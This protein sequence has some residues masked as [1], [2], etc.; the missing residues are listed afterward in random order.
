[1]RRT[2]LGTCALWSE[3]TGAAQP[4]VGVT[5]RGWAGAETNLRAI[6]QN[7]IHALYLLNVIGRVGFW[8]SIRSQ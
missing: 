3:S 6:V 1:M 2:A 4:T 7:T 5:Q 8:L